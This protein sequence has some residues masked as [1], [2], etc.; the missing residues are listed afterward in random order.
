VSG[1][2]GIGGGGVPGTGGLCGCACGPS[3]VRL[4]VS[5]QSASGGNGVIGSLIVQG[6]GLNMQCARSGCQFIC[7][8][9]QSGDFSVS[10]LGE[11]DYSLSVSAPGYQPQTVTVHVTKSCTCCGCCLSST[12]DR[13]EL[14]PDGSPITG[15]CA[16]LMTD[17]SNCGTCGKQCDTGTWCARGTCTPP[18]SPCITANSGFMSCAAYCASVGKTCMPAC[19]PSGTESLHWWGQ[20][21]TNCGDNVYSSNG[22]CSDNLIGFGARCCCG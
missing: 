8:S 14:V 9:T 5:A 15:C 19:G 18:L 1:N 12:P 21:S 3:A 20:G 11:G 22:S 16:D 10:G 4:Q 13:V 6:S 7:N 2:G 17:P